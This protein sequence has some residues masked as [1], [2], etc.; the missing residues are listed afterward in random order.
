V[1]IGL[2]HG[3]VRPY[4]VGM[5]NAQSTESVSLQAAIMAR[6]EALLSLEAARDA[7]GRWTSDLLLQRRALKQQRADLEEQLHTLLQC[8]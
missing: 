6:N 5:T 7:E 3:Y 8:M 1:Q 4:G 2:E